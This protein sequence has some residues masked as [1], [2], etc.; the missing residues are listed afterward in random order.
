MVAE[1]MKNL[2]MVLKGSDAYMNRDYKTSGKLLVLIQDSGLED[3]GHWSSKAEILYSLE[4]GSMLR[5]I[6]VA[7]QN[8][9]NVFVMCSIL[10]DKT[11]EFSETPDQ[12]AFRIW[13]L[14]TNDGRFY[15]EITFVGH[16]EGG[17]I[18]HY[19]VAEK[20]VSR[21]TTKIAF[22]DSEKSPHAFMQLAKINEWL[23]AG[24]A[25]HFKRKCSAQIVTDNNTFEPAHP[26]LMPHL[27]TEKILKFIGIQMRVAVD[28]CFIDTMAAFGY[29]ENS[30]H[31]D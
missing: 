3:L 16:G 4:I 25:I 17:R 1:K 22:I 8:N 27:A 14:L 5:I 10:L 28:P 31:F 24:T 15:H 30:K 2:G 18:A 21:M 29:E 9:M 7:L 13:N 23:K 19:L 11:R 20:N 12:H 6:E 26:D